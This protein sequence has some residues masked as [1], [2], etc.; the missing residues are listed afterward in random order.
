MAKT[1]NK[2]LE[3]GTEM[4]RKTETVRHDAGGLNVSLVGVP[5]YR[6]PK[7]GAH[8]VA[9]VNLGGLH[10]EIA[11]ALARRPERLQSAE[12]RFMR[13][14]LGLS[15]EDLAKRLKTG[16]D[17]VKHWEAKR[18][19]RMNPQAEMLLRLHVLM[20]QAIE[21]YGLEEVSLTDAPPGMLKAMPDDSSWKVA[22]A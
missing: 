12:I 14:Y 20:D 1:N 13:K 10:R 9:I 2:C 16:L 21:G 7:C 8:E 6:C 15:M 17:T 22:A 3:C 5:V 4:K 11:H 19:R 18:A